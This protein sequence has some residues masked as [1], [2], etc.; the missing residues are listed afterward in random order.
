MKNEKPVKRCENCYFYYGTNGY[1]YCQR[2]GDN[3]LNCGEERNNKDDLIMQ[4]CG[5]DAKFFRQR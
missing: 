3:W 5:K 2:K 4:H 1:H